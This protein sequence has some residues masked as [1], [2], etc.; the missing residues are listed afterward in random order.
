MKLRIGK[1]PYANLF[2]IFYM[3]EKKCDCST[4]EF[5]EG[6]PSLLNKMIR[7]GK[8]D[9]S[10][11][12]SIEYI[13]NPFLYQII[14]GNSISSRGPI[15]SIFLFTKKD[16]HELNGNIVYVSSQS[17][18]SV[19]LLN[20]IL[21]KFYDI[22]CGIQVSQRP[23]DSG[24]DAFLLIGDDA[25]RY[26]AISNRQEAIGK[27][28]DKHTIH[29][30]LPIVSHQ[31]VYDL[32]EI[33]YE[34]T[35][36]PFV[37]ALWI[38]RKDMFDKREILNKFIKDLNK[39]KEIASKNLYEIARHSPMKEF[40]SEKEIVSYWRLIDYDLKAEHKKGLKLFERYLKEVDHVL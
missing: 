15:G 4:Y 31:F 13:R 14:E 39:A 18:T 19:A 23:E 32:G 5:V 40:M 27:N 1:I 30:Q 10:P 16:I 22:Q 12:S 3:L 29:G 36:L 28:I 25:L 6:V 21:K 26:K 17:E 9:V 33:W 24:A 7:D 2:P 34:K 35:G 11:S 8:I 20:I 38:A 37:F